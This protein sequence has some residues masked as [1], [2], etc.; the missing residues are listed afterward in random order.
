VGVSDDL[1]ARF[2]G[3]DGP[4]PIPDDARRRIEA[5]LASDAERP[6]PADFRERLEHALIDG[7]AARPMPRGLRRRLQRTMTTTT[8][9]SRLRIAGV[10][11]AALLTLLGS[12]VLIT[13]DDGAPRD[14]V[15]SAA[16]GNQPA[17][18]DATSGQGLAGGGAEPSSPT[19]LLA[20][21]TAGGG[22][23]ASSAAS[24]RAAPAT[25]PVAVAVVGGDADEEAG[26][27]A[28][29]DEQNRQGGRFDLVA[30]N[31]PAVVTVNLSLQAAPP[32]DGVVMEGSAAQDGSLRGKVF[33]V[34]GAAD[35]QA[36]I[37]ASSAFPKNEPGARAVIYTGADEPFARTLPAAFEAVLRQRGV[38]SVRV[39][40]DGSAHPVLPRAD[41]AFLS[42]PPA[43]AATWL[44][45]ARDANYEPGH[46]TWGIFSAADESFAEGAPSGFHVVSPFTLP[47]SNEAAAIRAATKRRL[48]ARVVH[49][50]LTAKY[51][52]T[53]I[54]RSDA[55]T[56]AELADALAALQGFD[57]G[58][59][60]AYATRAGTHSRTPEA[61][62]LTATGGRFV[63]GNGFV[64]D[65]S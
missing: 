63:P 47:A 17:G 36:H 54:R 64:R 27:R 42:L 59:A 20:G 2:S 16:K 46:G 50:W 21:G 61:I 38:T 12:V 65:T 49:G 39:P 48:S 33:D 18:G 4:R 55:D 28:Y 45:S 43:S 15:T 14:R 24:G 60:P 13:G 1:A 40:Y 37:A 6:M 10:V 31:A 8:V 30:A 32:S 35:R 5:I 41:A 53:A 22:T 44:H 23:G 62:V 9:S 52:V 57:D 11:A 29:I 56:P 19:T 58:F 34:A 26:F 3:I 25:R 7:V 51:L